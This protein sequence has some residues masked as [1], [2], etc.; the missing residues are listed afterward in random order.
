MFIRLKIVCLEILHKKDLFYPKHFFVSIFEKFSKNFFLRAILFFLK[1]LSNSGGKIGFLCGQRILTNF[2]QN[3]YQRSFSFL[4]V[5][6]YG[7]F[8]YFNFLYFQ[9]Y[10]YAQL[11]IFLRLII[12]KLK[13][14]LII[15]S[16]VYII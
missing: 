4:F 16:I 12:I 13:M 15:Y 10:S 3:Y 5:L 8:G 7:E 11:K 9:K 6:Q 14:R 2:S 1:K